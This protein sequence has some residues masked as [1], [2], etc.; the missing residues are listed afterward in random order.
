VKLEKAVKE[1]TCAAAGTRLLSVIVLVALVAVVAVNLAVGSYKII[2]ELVATAAGPLAYVRALSPLL[3]SIL[4]AALFAGALAHLSRAL[5]EFEAG[6]F[7]T[8]SSCRA[9]RRAGVDAA[10]ALVAQAVM[11][12]T[13]LAWVR[14]EAGFAFNVELAD[15]A[16]G[17][18]LVFVAAVGRVL[19]IAAAVQAENDA[20]V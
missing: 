12:P 18:F 4:P 3:I 10:W 2:A 8:P 17:A 1:T 11:V 20:I 6:R 15:L 13:L 14:H 5:K 9:V 7:F 16:L 19:E